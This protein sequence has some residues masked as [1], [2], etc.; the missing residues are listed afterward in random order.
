[1]N[2]NHH[3]DNRSMRTKKGDVVADFTLGHSNAG[4]TL[5][6]LPKYKPGVIVLHDA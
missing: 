4:T 2:D 6:G 3:S 5:K 1:M